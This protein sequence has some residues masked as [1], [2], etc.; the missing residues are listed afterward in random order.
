MHAARL[1]LL[2]V[3]QPHRAEGSVQA[4]GHITFGSWDVISRGVDP[5]SI[6]GRRS[7]RVGGAGRA[8]V[9]RGWH[10]FLRVA[11]LAVCGC[12]CSAEMCVTAPRNRFPRFFSTSTY[13]SRQSSMIISTCVLVQYTRIVKHARSARERASAP[14]SCLATAL[15]GGWRYINTRVCKRTIGRKDTERRGGLR[16]RRTGPCPARPEIM[17]GASSAARGR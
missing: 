13:R 11:C 6:S 17:W 2:Q 8:A 15:R 12:T 5:Q 14:H 7:G 1:H 4:D 10:S 16:S 9:V 3:V